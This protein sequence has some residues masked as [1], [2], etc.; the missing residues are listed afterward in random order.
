MNSLLQLLYIVSAIRVSRTCTNSSM[1][2]CL[3]VNFIWF[4]KFFA[5]RMHL[6]DIIAMRMKDFWSINAINVEVS[7][8]HVFS[9]DNLSPTSQSRHRHKRSQTSVND[10]L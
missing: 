10:V 8:L 2:V 7:P 1:T 4:V 9:V 6:M 3:M 5:G